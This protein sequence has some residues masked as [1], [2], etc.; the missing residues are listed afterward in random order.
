MDAPFCFGVADEDEPEWDEPSATWVGGLVGLSALQLSA[1]RAHSTT[2]TSAQICRALL[3]RGADGSTLQV[4]TSSTS[5]A[6]TPLL[7]VVRTA[8]GDA[9]DCPICCERGP[10]LQQRMDALLR[11]ALPRP[12]P[13]SADQVPH[14]QDGT[15]CRPM[16]QLQLTQASGRMCTIA[17]GPL[18]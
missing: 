7:Q 15:P 12:L 16:R 11:D 17:A 3:S 14:V 10:H 5:T 9:L 18:F 1:Q 8:E 6:M 13:H 4:A 2:D